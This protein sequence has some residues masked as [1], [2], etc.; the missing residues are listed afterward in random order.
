MEIKECVFIETG[1]WINKE[2]K[3][4]KRKNF[5]VKYLIEEFRLEYKNKGIFKSAYYYSSLNQDEAYLYGDFYLDFDSDNFEYVLEDVK[6]SIYYIK[7]VFEIDDKDIKVFYSGKKGIH[8]IINAYALGVEPNTNLNNIFKLIARKI[9]EF[10]TNKTL[11]LRIYD[12]KRMFRIENSI[13]EGSGLYK[14][15]I[16]Q[17]IINNINSDNIKKYAEYKKISPKFKNE[18]N[19]AAN[20][21]Y[22]TFVDNWDVELIKINNKK[23]NTKNILTYMPPCIKEILDFGSDNGKRNNTVAI[24]SSYFYASGLELKQA[25]EKIDTWNKEKNIVPLCSGETYNTV[26]SIY[27]KQTKL[28]C[29]TIKDLEL[30]S[31]N[32][33]KF[34]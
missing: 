2:K 19:V 7:T 4:F 31:E 18:I 33:C 22:K 13:H 24:L 27:S 29:S 15:Y 12:K 8:I 16:P 10:T 6:K 34:R 26:S 17:E 5:T 14:V 11:D 3:I 9:N 32:N 20:K 23:G 1:V 28:G 21:S 25:F 30:C